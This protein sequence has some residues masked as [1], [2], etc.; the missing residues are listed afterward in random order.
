MYS[1][2]NNLTLHYF[3][4]LSNMDKTEPFLLSLREISL[5]EVQES[6]LY[7]K[8]AYMLLFDD[9]TKCMWTSLGVQET[10]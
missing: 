7:Y 9:H 10:M 8:Y 5:S 6:N 4:R 2:Y 1:L 3:L